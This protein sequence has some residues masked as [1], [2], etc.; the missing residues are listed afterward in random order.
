MEP[1]IILRVRFRTTEE[2]GRQN[3]VGGEVYACPLFVGEKAFDCRLFKKGMTLELGQWY[4][5][6]VKFMN[7]NLALAGLNVGKKISLWEGKTIADGEVVQ[8]L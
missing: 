7:K 3:A 1:D 8:I 2:G 4:E 5:L 6:P